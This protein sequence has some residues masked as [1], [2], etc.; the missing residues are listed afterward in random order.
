[1]DP[2]AILQQVERIAASPVFRGSGRLCGFLQ[3]IVREALF[4]DAANLKESRIAVEAYGRDS[5]KYQ[6]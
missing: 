1:M 6:P 5:R 2:A 4:G 3:F